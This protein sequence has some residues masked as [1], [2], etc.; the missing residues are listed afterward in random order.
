[1]LYYYT[2]ILHE[3]KE[4]ENEAVE[5]KRKAERGERRKGL[6]VVEWGKGKNGS[7]LSNL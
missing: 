4:E 6:E 7:S 3:K 5:E 1:M 2:F